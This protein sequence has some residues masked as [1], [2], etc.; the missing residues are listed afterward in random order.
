MNKLENTFPKSSTKIIDSYPVITGK[1]SVRFK[2]NKAKS[3]TMVT[4][5]IIFLRL[6]ISNSKQSIP[7]PTIAINVLIS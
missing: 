3:A 1:L 4:G 2:P 7:I 6:K 5:I